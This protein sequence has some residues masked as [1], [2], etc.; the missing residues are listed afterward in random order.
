M[1]LVRSQVRRTQARPP[2][3]LSRMSRLGALLLVFGSGILAISAGPLQTAGATT[4]PPTWVQLFP[5]TGPAASYGDSMVLDPGIGKTVLFGGVGPTTIGLA[6]SDTE[7]DQTWTFDGS[8]WTQLFPA[9]SPSARDGAAMAYDPSIGKVILFGGFATGDNS[10][11]TFDGSNWTQLSTTTSPPWRGGASMD[12]D[13]AIGQMVL[14]GGYGCGE[15]LSNACNA[16][17]TFDGTNWTQL[18]STLPT[19]PPPRMDASM[20]FDP[21]LNQLLLVG[22]WPGFGP[23]MNDTW[24]FDGSTWTQLSPVTSPPARWGAMMAFDSTNNDMVLFGGYE[25]SASNDTWTFDGSNWTQQ[26][27]PLSPQPR[28]QGSMTYDPSLGQLVLYGGTGL[29]SPQFQDT[30]TWAGPFHIVTTSLA[31]ATSGT[32]YGPVTLSTEGVEV[33]SSPYATTLKWFGAELPKGMT[34]SSA[35][36]LSGT[37]NAK[38]VARS[39]SVVA[40]ATETVTSVTGRTK[41]KKNTTVAATIP[42]TVNGIVAS[43]GGFTISTPSLPN[44]APGSHYGPVTLQTTGAGTSSSPYGTTLKWFGA[45]LPK[46]MTLSSAGVLS[47][48]PNAK[49]VARSYSVVAQATETVTTVTGRTK[50]KTNTTVAATIPLIVS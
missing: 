37:P 16:T 36:V 38:L 8:A 41:V 6:G 17:W 19:S 33:S 42:I 3:I 39:Y 31:A 18:T 49:L 5:G 2:L 40:Q 24:T 26:T 46:G 48:T 23:G 27:P 14:F 45:E 11:W 29:Y 50:V 1:R 25:S 35:G 43:A 9:T 21:A 13:P 34:L 30:W 28:V 7:E 10:T 47:G 20:A 32:A 15:E 22:G 44:A 12:Y 4:Q